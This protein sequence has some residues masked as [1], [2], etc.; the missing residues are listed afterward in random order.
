[1]VR[2]N[3]DLLQSLDVVAEAFRQ[4]GLD[5]ALFGGLAVHLHTCAA[6]EMEEEPASPWEDL[7]FL[8]RMVRQTRDIDLALFGAS[9]ERVAAVLTELGF[10]RVAGQ[11]LYQ[12]GAVDAVQATLSGESLEGLLAQLAGELHLMKLPGSD[13]ELRIMGTA[14]LV[15]LK[16]V[17]WSTRYAERDLVDVAHLAIADVLQGNGTR[18]RLELL[19]PQMEED[20]RKAI[21]RML[22]SSGQ[23]RATGLL[24]D[25]SREPQRTAGR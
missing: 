5:P 2:G 22:A 15:V 1:V 10:T 3:E 25:G 6:G 13:R 23:P 4:H 17:A 11:A 12:S 21:E 19:V 7:A 14:G 24:Q 9:R 20:S 16:A 8:T 18:K